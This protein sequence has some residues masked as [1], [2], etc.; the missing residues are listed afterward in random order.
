MTFAQEMCS[1]YLNIYIIKP[2]FLSLTV[3]KTLLEKHF[4]VK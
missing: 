4:K 3:K 1:F 2:I